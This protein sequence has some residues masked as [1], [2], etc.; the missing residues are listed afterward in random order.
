MKRTLLLLLAL[1]CMLPA[2]HA[3]GPETLYPIAYCFRETDFRADTLSDLNGIFVT[4]KSVKRFSTVGAIAPTL[5]KLN[6]HAPCR[7][8][9][10]MS[11]RYSI[12]TSLPSAWNL[13]IS[14]LKCSISPYLQ[15]PL[16]TS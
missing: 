11:P 14:F 10:P 9:R 4:S 6:S 3:A 8:I 5:E 2:A 12:F 13:A 1:L 16:T 15:A 7:A